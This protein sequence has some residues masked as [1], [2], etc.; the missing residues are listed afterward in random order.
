M[1]SPPYRI[2]TGRLCIR[3]WHPADAPLLKDAIDSSLAHLRPWMPWA[4]DEPQPLEAKAE[5]LRRFRG[6]A[7]D[8][9]G[10]RIL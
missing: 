10:V 1:V 3:C 9:A 4:H 2:V 5:L 7:F 8:A 6:G